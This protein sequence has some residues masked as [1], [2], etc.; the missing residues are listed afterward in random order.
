MAMAMAMA[1]AA[2]MAMAA[3]LLRAVLLSNS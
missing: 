3:D 2:G 1:M